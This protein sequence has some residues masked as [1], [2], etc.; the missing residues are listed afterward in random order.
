MDWQSPL[1]LQDVE[2]YI[3]PGAARLTRCWGSGTGSGFK[4]TW[5]VREKIAALA[6]M[7]RAR[8]SAATAV[9]NGVRN[10]VRKAS[11]TLRIGGSACRGGKGAMARAGGPLPV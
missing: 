7:P 6:P 1:S 8:E 2:P 3:G 10:S 9:T 5:S 4:S 11:F